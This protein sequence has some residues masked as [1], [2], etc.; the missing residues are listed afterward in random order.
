M[1]VHEVMVQLAILEFKKDGKTERSSLKQVRRQ[2]KRS[3]QNQSDK[4]Q[5]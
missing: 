1:Y 5:T 4:D 3:Q 2:A